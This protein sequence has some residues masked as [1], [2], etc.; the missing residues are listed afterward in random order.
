MME[1]EQKPKTPEDEVH[2]DFRLWV[3]TRTFEGRLIP[4]MLIQHGLKVTCEMTNNFKSTLEKSYATAEKLFTRR[5][6]A[7]T[8]LRRV[9]AAKQT[10]LVQI[11][12]LHA[13]VLHRRNYGMAAFA[14]DMFWSHVD[15]SAL[16]EQFRIVMLL[17]QRFKGTRTSFKTLYSSMLQRVHIDRISCF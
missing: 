4:G 8:A 10:Y 17:C 11:S 13:L 9:F 6:R 15:L 16:I 1:E 5:E 14:R 7:P 2:E 3:T 12:L